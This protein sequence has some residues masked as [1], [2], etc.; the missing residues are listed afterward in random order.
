MNVLNP[1][2][3]DITLDSG[4]T[5]GALATQAVTVPSPMYTNVSVTYY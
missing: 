3:E 4:Q 1:G 2:T 5:I